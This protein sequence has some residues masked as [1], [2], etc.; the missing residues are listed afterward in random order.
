VGVQVPLSAPYFKVLSGDAPELISRRSLFVP[1]HLKQPG[2]ALSVKPQKIPLWLVKPHNIGLRS[3]SCGLLKGPRACRKHFR[4][5]PAPWK[6][7]AA[8]RASQP[9]KS[10]RTVPQSA[11]RRIRSGPLIYEAAERLN[12]TKSHDKRGIR[13]RRHC[14][15]T[16]PRGRKNRL[17]VEGDF[18]ACVEVRLDRHFGVCFGGLGPHRNPNGRWFV[19]RTGRIS[20]LWWGRSARPGRGAVRTWREGNG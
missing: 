1:A 16:G 5:P 2:T 9:S 13:H 6:F 4:P 20:G 17:E 8:T 3:G 10:P 14:R 11:S 15:S 7:P 12:K 19:F 18:A